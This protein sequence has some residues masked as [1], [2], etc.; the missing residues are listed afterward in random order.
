MSMSQ[1]GDIGTGQVQIGLG[2]QALRECHGHGAG[3]ASAFSLLG[4]QSGSSRF[5][6]PSLDPSSSW[7]HWL[8]ASLSS[9][10]KEP[11]GSSIFP[12]LDPLPQKVNH[13]QYSQL[14]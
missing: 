10:P 7:L 1:V 3:F 4:L 11:G 6:H 2:L 9:Y 14:I 8:A 12:C 5:L 13:T